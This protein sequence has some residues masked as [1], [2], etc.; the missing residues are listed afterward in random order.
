MQ[1]DTK[2]IQ[3]D[4]GKP[5]DV[6]NQETL[7]DNM[8]ELMPSKSDEE[9]LEEMRESLEKLQI[10]HETHLTWLYEFHRL[11]TTGEINRNN[12]G[13]NWRN[14]WDQSKIRVEELSQE[15]KEKKKKSKLLKKG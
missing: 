6:F 15:I 2:E 14:K 7:F 12:N 5:K 8:I 13:D 4:K 1:N 3:E 10:E 11:S 9:V